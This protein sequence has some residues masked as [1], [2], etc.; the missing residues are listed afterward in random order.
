MSTGLFQTRPMGRDTA[1]TIRTAPH[2][3]SLIPP[4]PHTFSGASDSMAVSPPIYRY[5][6]GGYDNQV[7]GMCV[8]KG[9]KNAGATILRIP[10]GASFDPA[11]PQSAPAPG[12][13]VR[14]SGLFCYHNARTVH[15]FGGIGEGAVVAYSMDGVM[16]FGYALEGEWPDTEAN[17]KS[18]SDRKA[19]PAAALAE[20]AKHVVLHAARIVSRQQYFDFQAQGFPVI[21]G[22]EIGQG[23]MNTAEDGK[24]SLGGR[25]VGGHC[26]EG[27]GYDRNLNRQYIR[28]SWVDWG[29]VDRSNPEFNSDDPAFGGNANGFTNV[30]YCPLDEWEDTFITDAK[31]SS[32]ETDAFVVSDIPGFAAPK[33]ALLSSGSAF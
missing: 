23:W 29:A 30:G 24:F 20:G 6:P 1:E 25:S 21:H 12:P 26:T 16:K 11:N 18:Y 22:V 33:I 2:W 17:Q 32:G 19:V 28:N 27:C 14:L 15:G 7:I 9:T 8:G 4:A 31:L 3:M 10:P 5:C 13:N